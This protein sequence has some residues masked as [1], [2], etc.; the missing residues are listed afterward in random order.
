MKKIIYVEV[1]NK[2]RGGGWAAHPTKHFAKVPRRKK[3]GT[4]VGGGGSC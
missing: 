3:R 2:L 4:V 1:K